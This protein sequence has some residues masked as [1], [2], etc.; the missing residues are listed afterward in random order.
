M[1][2]MRPEKRCVSCGLVIG[3]RGTTS[4]PCPNCGNVTIG[5]CQQ[6]RDQGVAYA[7]PECGF[8]GP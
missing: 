2:A 7:C 3:G 8:R 5:R 1:L 4:F 6:C